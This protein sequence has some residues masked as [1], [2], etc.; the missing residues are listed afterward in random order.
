MDKNRDFPPIGFKSQ[1]VYQFHIKTETELCFNELIWICAWTA[2]ILISKNIFIRSNLN[3]ENTVMFE[4]PCVMIVPNFHF[5]QL[6]K[7]VFG[8]SNKF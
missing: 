3:V 2:N 6:K 1:N 7:T 8:F 4:R 5:K